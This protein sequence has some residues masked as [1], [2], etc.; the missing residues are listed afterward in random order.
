MEKLLNLKKLFIIKKLLNLKVRSKLLIC[1]ISISLYISLVGISSYISMKAIN[2]GNDHIYN[3]N[4]VSIQTL[5]HI[6]KNVISIKSEMEIILLKKN[7]TVTQVKIDR[8]NNF[9]DENSKLLLQY[10]KVNIMNGQDENN[11]KLNST[12]TSNDKLIVGLLDLI[13]EGKFDESDDLLQTFSSVSS[14]L[15]N[16]FQNLIITHKESARITNLSNRNLFVKSSIIILTI[17]VSGFIIAILLGVLISG[18]IAKSLNKSVYFAESLS[19][20]DL[21]KVIDIDLND[22]IGILSKALNKASKNT[23]KL[24]VS[25]I[26]QVNK[27]NT[28]NHNIYQSTEE[29]SADIQSVHEST[30]KINNDINI[31]NSGVNNISDLSQQMIS[32]IGLISDKAIVTSG[33]SKGI[34][35]R[36][37]KVK[38]SALESKKMVS[39]IYIEKQAKILKAIENGKVVK[40]IKVMSD[41]ID[42]ISKQTKLLSLNAAIEA[43]RAGNQGRGFAVVADEIGKLAVLS[44]G[45]VSDIK[46]MV[47]LVEEAFFYIAESSN[48]ILELID[49]KI[50]KDYDLMIFMGNDYQKDSEYM[51][52]FSDYLVYNTSDMKNTIDKT[53]TS[54]NSVIT[55]LL[56][57]GG[58]SNEIAASVSETSKA[59]EYIVVGCQDGANKGEDLRQLVQQFK[60]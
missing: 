34:K 13:S 2:M 57:V 46:N 21:T 20:G 11:V 5:A 32:S 45:A 18:F 53:N 7:A 27:V 39:S 43:A 31:I 17:T 37:T 14:N 1:F 40:E 51:D 30:Y 22:E 50:S 3:N 4:L 42:N 38:N 59:M 55:L 29:I 26:E 19:K 52:A 48:E 54:I 24:V 33:I 12:N 25:I 23:K 28:D 44:T 10:N 47:N 9:L 58:S 49:T 41:L 60:I 16:D 8:V 15:D 36:A 35:E 6:Q 56:E